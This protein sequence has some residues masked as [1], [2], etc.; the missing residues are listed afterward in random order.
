MRKRVMWIEN[1]SGN[2]GLVG[3][4][5]IGWVTFS[6][7]GKSIRYGGKSFASLHGSGFNATYFDEN[8]REHYW[9]SGCRKDGVDG[10]YETT[11]EI[12]HDA[13]H[14]YWVNIRNLPQNI[15]VLSLSVPGKY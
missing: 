8:T 2:G 14:E 7:S 9:I 13:A 3:P 6:K 11:A 15:G 4:A 1:K 5:R 12:D 10:L